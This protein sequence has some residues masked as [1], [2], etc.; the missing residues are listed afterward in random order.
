M[1]RKLRVGSV[2][3]R[4]DSVKTE[5]WVITHKNYPGVN[6]DIYKT[7]HVGRALSG[8]LGYQGDNTGDNISSKNKSY[9]EL[10]GLYWLWK[11]HECDIMGIC[12]YFR[13]SREC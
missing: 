11:K 7:L 3:E 10:T 5:M 13:F 12:H 9:C 4:T 6:D 8:D 2:W 1:R